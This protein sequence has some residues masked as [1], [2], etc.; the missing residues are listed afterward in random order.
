MK[1]EM[2]FNFEKQLE[3]RH[4][5]IAFQLFCSIFRGF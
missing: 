2:Q 3:T 1:K 4:R 5:N